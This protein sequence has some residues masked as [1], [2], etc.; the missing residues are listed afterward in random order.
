MSG[1]LPSGFWIDQRYLI[2][3]AM[4][5]LGLIASLV[6]IFS[7]SVLKRMGPQAA[8]RYSTFLA[9]GLFLL[10][11]YL[12][13]AGSQVTVGVWWAV[14]VG[15]IGGIAIGLITE[16]YTSAG[17]VT[18]IALASKTGSATTVEALHRDRR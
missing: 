13:V 12:L 7:M 18:R 11:A 1:Q 15:T 6:G 14:V 10:F 9:A 4:A 16:Y 2:P 3:L 5:V 17:P 8:L